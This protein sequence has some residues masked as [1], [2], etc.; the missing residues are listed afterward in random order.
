MSIVEASFEEI[1]FGANRAFAYAI[2]ATET[3]NGYVTLYRLSKVF[4][5]LERFLPFLTP[6]YLASLTDGQ[7][8]RL[9]FCMQDIH[10][11]LVRFLRSPEAERF[12]RFLALQG[13]VN[14][15][16]GG[17]DDLAEVLDG[18]PFA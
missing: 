2:L 5:E 14:R 6:D 9:R 15:L 13:F 8:R 12:G 10:R 16:Q 7:K 3:Q 4:A 1:E 18:M 11:L 17:T